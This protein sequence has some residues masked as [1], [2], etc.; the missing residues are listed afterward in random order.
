MGLR[1]KVQGEGFRVLSHGRVTAN[2]Q[3]CTFRRGAAALAKN[4]SGKRWHISHR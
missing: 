1:L 3:E 2:S 4:M